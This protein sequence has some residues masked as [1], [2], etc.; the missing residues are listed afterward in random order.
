[1]INAQ[2][3]KD[4]SKVN[5]R[6]IPDVVLASEKLDGIW[7]CIIMCD[8]KV[9]Y[10]HTR[11]RESITNC[12][13]IKQEAMR[14][15]KFLPE[16]KHTYAMIGELTIPDCKAAQVTARCVTRKDWQEQ[17]ATFNV[18]DLV[19]LDVEYECTSRYIMY[20]KVLAYMTDLEHIKAVNK[21]PMHKDSIESYV[22][23]IWNRGG[24]GAVFNVPNS[25]YK[26]SA[27]CNDMFKIKE[28]IDFDL[29]CIGFVEGEGKFKGMVGSLIVRDKVGKEFVV[30]GGTM[31]TAERESLWESLQYT[32]GDFGVCEV[33]CMLVTPDGELR[34][35][36][37][38]GWRPDKTVQDIQEVK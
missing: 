3:A 34:E 38:N 30:G 21:T 2:K 31:S 33:K 27:R 4:F 32:F 37:F 19:D 29:L 6:T 20:M 9:E 28:C 5:F 13:S 35:P 18:F 12:D 16:R 17:D 25:M 7:A 22:S 26:Q 1:M 15:A 10:F 23:D 8:N 36:R 24:E 14:I 11:G